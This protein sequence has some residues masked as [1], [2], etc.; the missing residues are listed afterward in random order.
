MAVDNSVVHKYQAGFTECAGEVNRYLRT[1]DGLDPKVKDRLLGH[2]AGCVQR[3]GTATPPIAASTQRQ[4][5]NN[6]IPQRLPS[7]PAVT[8]TTVANHQAA[9]IMSPL[10]VNCFYTYTHLFSVETIYQSDHLTLFT[11]IQPVFISPLFFQVQIPTAMMNQHSLPTPPPSADIPTVMAQQ[12]QQQQQHF[13]SLAH[14]QGQSMK[15]ATLSQRDVVTYHLMANQVITSAQ[16]AMVA[17]TAS[18]H[19]GTRAADGNK[20]NNQQ[21]QNFQMFSA[22]HHRHQQQPTQIMPQD[23]HHHFAGNYGNIHQQQQQLMYG[24][25]GNRSSLPTPR[26]STS[27]PSPSQQSLSPPPRCE[28]GDSSQSVMS[29]ESSPT[30][31]VE[32]NRFSPLNS[33]ACD[34]ASPS[35]PA[36]H[37]PP[38]HY[39]Y[40]NGSSSPTHYSA[41]VAA[42]EGSSREMYPGASKERCHHDEEMYNVC[43]AGAIDLSRSN[44]RYHEGGRP[45]ED[46]LDDN[47]NVVAQPQ[48]ANNAESMWRPW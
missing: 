4:F 45:N 7:N 32:F 5:P 47:R 25:Y 15:N 23:R 30:P 3:M 48:Q 39:R 27:T 14:S 21:L 35:A 42:M 41:H 2:L 16:M 17:Q 19:R 43:D 18:S 11:I 38:S 1:I 34:S 37:S 44:S 46:E 12:Q 22:H 26:H 10:Q 13:T 29:D 6:T 8:F 20:M 28:S 9:S 33:R 24:Y 40:G 31:A 36:P